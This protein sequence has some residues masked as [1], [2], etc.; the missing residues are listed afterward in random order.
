MRKFAR[1]GRPWSRSASS[2][3]TSSS[4]RSTGSAP[5]ASSTRSPSRR[6][7]SPRCQASRSGAAVSASAAAASASAHAASGCARRSEA[8]TA[9]EPV[10]QLGQPPREVDRAALDAEREHALPQ[11]LVGE[12]DAGE[13]PVEPGAPRARGEPLE[14]VG[15]AV[16]RVEPPAHAGLAHPLLGAGELVVVE[17]EAAAH[18]RPV[19]QV[20]HLRGGEPLAREVEQPRDH[21]EQ[22]V[23][24]AQRAVGEPDLEERLLLARPEGGVDERREGLDVGAHHDHVARLERRVVGERV[25]HG[26]AQHLDLPRAAVAGVDADAAVR[27]VEH[28]AARRRRPAAAARAAARRRGSRPGSPRAGSARAAARRGGGRRARPRARAR[29]GARARR[30]PTRR[31]GG[32]AAATR[33]GRR[34]G[35]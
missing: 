17:A 18:R 11:L 26:V 21:A 7:S 16:G 8:S 23:G 31:A 20:E 10:E 6:S 22:R 32:C 3:R 33:S 28:A 13:Q 19:G 4:T 1:V 34:G 5:S 2:A 24:L 14:L 25:Q 29:A 30:S 27:R 9:A 12:R 15:L 35:S